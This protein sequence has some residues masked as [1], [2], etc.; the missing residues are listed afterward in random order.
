MGARVQASFD[1][2]NRPAVTFALN[3]DRASFAFYNNSNDVDC[4][5]ESLKKMKSFF[6]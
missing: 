6:L 2:N 3:A 4:L 1:Q 5:V